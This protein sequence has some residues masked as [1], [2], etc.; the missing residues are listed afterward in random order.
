M[1]TYI[2]KNIHTYI[3]QYIHT[4]I[5]TYVPP[6]PPPTHTHA[7]TCTPKLHL[8]HFGARDTAQKSQHK[9]IHTYICMYVY[10]YVRT[11]VLNPRTH[12]HAQ[13][14]IHSTFVILKRKVLR[15]SD[16]IDHPNARA[17]K[18]SQKSDLCSFNPA[19]S[20]AICLFRISVGHP[21]PERV[22]ILQ[23]Q[24]ATATSSAFT[25]C[26]TLQHTATHRPMVALAIFSRVSLL[27]L[28]VLLQ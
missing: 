10:T 23:S 9:H 5:Q 1:T 7:H 13:P 27:L 26:N 6:L 19:N 28:P 12:T 21:N 15:R 2:Y 8:G 22:E 16:T 20:T 24:L 11:Y 17:G 4:H 14:H 18:D 25:H 3:H